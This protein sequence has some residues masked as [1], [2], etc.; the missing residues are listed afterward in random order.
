MLVYTEFQFEV[1]QGDAAL[2]EKFFENFVNFSGGAIELVY[3]LVGMP[4][5]SSI[6]NRWADMVQLISPLPAMLPRFR[7]LKAVASSLKWVSKISLSSVE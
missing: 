2:T 7:A 4:L 3:L 6:R 5:A 1:Y